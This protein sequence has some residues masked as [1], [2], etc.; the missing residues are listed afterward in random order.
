MKTDRYTK[1]ILTIIAFCLMAN[2]L[3]KFDI[4]P[5][6]YA[7]EP[8]HK[9]ISPEPEPAKYGLVPLNADGSINVT[10]KNSSTLDVNLVDISTFDELDV[11]I[12]EV[13]GYS[14]YGEIPVKIKQ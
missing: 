1:I 13:G 4:M 10:V 6:A 2:M 7:A 8:T 11:N 12:D 3:E 9:P 14:T 5:T